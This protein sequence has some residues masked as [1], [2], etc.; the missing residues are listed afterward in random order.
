MQRDCYF[1]N[2]DSSTSPK[3][4]FNLNYCCIIHVTGTSK[5][6]SKPP[7]F[8]PLLL[9]ISHWLWIQVVSFFVSKRNGCLLGL[10]PKL[11]RDTTISCPPQQANTFFSFHSYLFCKDGIFNSSPIIMWQCSVFHDFFPCRQSTHFG[12]CSEGC[13]I[14]LRELSCLRHP[15]GKLVLWHHN[16]TIFSIFFH[17]FIRRWNWTYSGSKI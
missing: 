4:V 8:L 10:P 11:P 14:L 3:S 6:L 16:G 7:S 17:Y 5:P 2:N 9:F 15:V 12:V 1:I 13:F